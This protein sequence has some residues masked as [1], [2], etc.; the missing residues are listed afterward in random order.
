M[1][2]VG[3]SIRKPGSTTGAFQSPLISKT[4]AEHLKAI[5]SIPQAQRIADRPTGAI[6]LAI[7]AV[8][9]ALM[10]YS[11]GSEVVPLGSDGHFSQ[12]VWGDKFTLVGG[13][14]K[15]YKTT[16]NIHSL[17]G[18]NPVKNID[19]V[20][21]T[22]WDRIITSAHTHIAKL[23]SERTVKLP[24]PVLSEPQSDEDWEIPDIDPETFIITTFATEK[25]AA[26]I[27]EEEFIKGEPAQ[28]SETTGSDGLSTGNPG[29]DSVGREGA[30][31]EV[32][33]EE[34]E[35]E[36]RDNDMTTEA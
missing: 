20:S 35:S 32:F 33:D 11:T 15:Q 14:K 24:A 3:S 1:S 12:A 10:F 30:D 29:S 19:R 28:T 36:F 18:R 13:I 17:F 26:N 5:E 25:D 2:E 9:R 16:S 23:G 8:H 21:A 27:T 7:L 31:F 34:S 4:F 6:V 22:Q